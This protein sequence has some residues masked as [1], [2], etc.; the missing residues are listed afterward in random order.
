MYDTLESPAL[1][2]LLVQLHAMYGAV[3]GKAALFFQVPLQCSLEC[4]FTPPF[5]DMLV[6]LLLINEA[7]IHAFEQ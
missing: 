1:D 2:L 6:F 4:M 7:A 5:P 3:L